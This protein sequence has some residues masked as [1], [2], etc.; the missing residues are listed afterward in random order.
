MMKRYDVRNLQVLLE[1]QHWTIKCKKGPLYVYTSCV[2]KWR[3]II[4]VA[5]AWHRDKSETRF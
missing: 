1:L 2:R 5:M 3:I 4:V